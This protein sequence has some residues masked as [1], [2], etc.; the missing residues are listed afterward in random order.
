MKLLESSKSSSS[1][2]SPVEDV[3]GR[4]FLYGMNFGD[5]SCFDARYYLRSININN[6]KKITME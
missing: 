4:T 5:L 6:L 2:Q 3:R 1:W